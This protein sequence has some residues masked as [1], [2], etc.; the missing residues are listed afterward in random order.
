[1]ILRAW[2]RATPLLMLLLLTVAACQTAPDADV[3][4]LPTQ[5]VAVSVPPMATVSAPLLAVTF[6]AMRGPEVAYTSRR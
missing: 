1:M 2:R 4:P 3:A 5:A 6:S